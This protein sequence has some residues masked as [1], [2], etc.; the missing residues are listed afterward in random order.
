MQNTAA[1]MRMRQEDVD[2]DYCLVT[3]CSSC[4]SFNALPAKFFTVLRRVA[5][6]V[7]RAPDQ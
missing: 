6:A 7:Y 4:L 5:M 2:S 3:F 1:K